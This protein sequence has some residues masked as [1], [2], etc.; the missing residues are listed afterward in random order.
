ML[1]IAT[2]KCKQQNKGLKVNNKYV[3]KV[4]LLHDFQ[5]GESCFLAKS[6]CNSTSINYYRPIEKM[7]YPA[8]YL[9]DLVWI[10][11]AGS[12]IWFNPLSQGSF[13][14]IIM[15]RSTFSISNLC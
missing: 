12:V 2:M 4:V 5:L 6:L 7:F 11:M 3:F 8:N 13:D 15:Y 9:A 1:K 14:K 10:G